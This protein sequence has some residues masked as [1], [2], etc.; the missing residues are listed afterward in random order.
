MITNEYLNKL[1]K[2]DLI[3]LIEAGHND[4]LS[5]VTHFS[6]GLTMIDPR[7]RFVPR[8]D[9]TEYSTSNTSLLCHYV[10]SIVLTSLALLTLCV[11]VCI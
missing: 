1:T 9:Y 6:N 8:D 7:T 5:Q 11:I 2:K 10:V 3:A 4:K